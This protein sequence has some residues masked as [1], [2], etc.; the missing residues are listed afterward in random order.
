VSNRTE[1]GF[2]DAG[3]QRIVAAN[4]LGGH[5]LALQDIVWSRPVA[6]VAPHTGAVVYLFFIMI[7]TLIVI[8]FV[9]ADV[10]ASR[11]QRSQQQDDCCLSQHCCGDSVPHRLCIT[12]IHGCKKPN[13][14]TLA[15]SELASN[16][17]GAC[18]ELASVM[19]FGLK[20]AD[21]SNSAPRRSFATT[22]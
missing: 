18:S 6:V 10:C 8:M 1:A 5:V 21:N 20:Q 2:A 7:M 19:E 4:A 9:H 17:F 11:C 15:S 13:S 14:I 16:M 3:Y 22:S 12:V